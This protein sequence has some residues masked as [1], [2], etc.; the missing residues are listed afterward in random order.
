MAKLKANNF[1]FVNKEQDSK[2]G[3]QTEKKIEKLDGFLKI[4]TKTKKKNSDP[5]T[6][7]SIYL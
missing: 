6:V 5:L 1:L 3:N 2:L 7:P 4:S